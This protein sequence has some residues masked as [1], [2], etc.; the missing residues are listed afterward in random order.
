MWYFPSARRMWDSVY[1]HA[2]TGRLALDLP[3][4]TLR[5]TV[6]G[7]WRD[8]SYLVT[9]LTIL[10]VFPAEKPFDFAP[11][12]PQQI[13]FHGIVT[14]FSSTTDV[15]QCQIAQGANGWDLT[16]AEWAAIKP[17]LGR[18][19]N[20][21]CHHDGR[22]VLN[23]VLRKVGTGLA[24]RKVEYGVSNWALAQY[25]YNRYRRDGRWQLIE[26]VLNRTRPVSSGEATHQDVI[27][28]FSPTV[29]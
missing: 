7:I 17:H 23:G 1:A 18:G 9:E 22:A 5:M 2:S 14:A 12:V 25:T 10:S 28:K 24:W 6:R 20:W 8:G 26:D 29:S 13:I 11:F 3:H 19:D 27:Q 15:T 16:D 21:R 4:G